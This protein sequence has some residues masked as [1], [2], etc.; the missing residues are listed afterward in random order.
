TH[1]AGFDILE[2]H[3]AHGYLIQQFLSPLVNKRN[4]A[5]GGDRAGRMRFAL[6]VAEAVRA[7]WPAEKPLFFRVSSVDGKGGLWDLDDTIALAHELKKRGVDC[8]DCS[9]GGLTG[10]SP[11]PIVP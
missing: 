4:D 6:E 11:M 9:S 10:D 8:I 2:I 1:R 7:A 3:G 5:Y